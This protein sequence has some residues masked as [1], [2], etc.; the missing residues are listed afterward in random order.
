MAS[1]KSIFEV[2]NK[3]DTIGFNFSS[4][5]Q[6]I[7]QVCEI[8]NERLPQK[9]E[10]IEP[11]LFAINL[12]IR[13]G[14]TNAVRH[15]NDNDPSKQVRFLMKI[16]PGVSVSMEIEDQGP[17][18]DWRKLKALDPDEAEDH[19]RGFLIIEAYFTSY[20]YNEAGN[21]LYLEKD[22]TD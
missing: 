11:H 14:L 18:F 8:I 10:G 21:I 19:G 9:M 5:M 15:G 6:N 12:V 13:E 4:T 22:L 20:S 1:E 2:S 7:D 3:N 17:G 16:N